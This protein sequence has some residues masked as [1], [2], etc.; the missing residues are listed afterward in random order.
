MSVVTAQY[1]RRS[2]LQCQSMSPHEVLARCSVGSFAIKSSAPTGRSALH[3][4]LT[5]GPA[6]QSVRYV[7]LHVQ[8]L[9]TCRELPA[10]QVSPVVRDAAPVHDLFNQC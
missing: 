3:I 9:T 10:Q 1:G 4:R 8:H 5:L 2:G 7:S 6:R